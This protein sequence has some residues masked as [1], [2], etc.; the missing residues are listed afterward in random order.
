MLDQGEFGVGGQRF[1]VPR[2]AGSLAALSH[3]SA[4]EL[5]TER[6]GLPG[7]QTKQSGTKT[8]ILGRQQTNRAHAKMVG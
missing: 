2:S 5:P 4:E 1:H 6:L 3:E 7:R 8:T